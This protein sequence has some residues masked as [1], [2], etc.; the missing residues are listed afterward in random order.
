MAYT[1]TNFLSNSTGVNYIVNTAIENKLQNYQLTKL[2]TLNITGGIPYPSSD[3]V[4]HKVDYDEEAGYFFVSSESLAHKV[5][6]NIFPKE[7]YIDNLLI[8]MSA[9]GQGVGKYIF[10]NEIIEARKLGYRYM[11]VSAAKG[12]RLN[13]YYT[14]ARF[15]YSMDEL[16]HESFLELMEMYRRKE[17]SIIQLM[18]TQDG[19]DFWLTNGFWWEGYFDLADGSENM[20]AFQH[21]LAETGID[22][23]L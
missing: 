2:N 1:Q 22:V 7:Q 23:S 19:R 11:T 12:N 10:I 13:G 14:W 8:Q 3:I 21:Y 16:D 5:E 17:T 15:G 6:R 18:K 4:I 9:T 20:M